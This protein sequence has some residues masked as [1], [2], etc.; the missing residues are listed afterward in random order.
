MPREYPPI[1]RVFALVREADESCQIV[2]YGM[3]L[4][5]GATYAA[6]WPPGRG[7]SFYSASSAEATASLRGATVLWISD[8]PQW[9]THG[10]SEL[11]WAARLTRGALRAL[12]VS[13]RTSW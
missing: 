3:V 12:G 13:A 2:G 9:A 8:Q 1:P 11:G 6:S 5:D 4:P 7:T 10:N